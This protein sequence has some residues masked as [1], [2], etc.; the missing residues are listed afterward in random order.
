MERR[1]RISFTVI[2]DLSYDQRMQRICQ[3]LSEAGYEVS[4]IG[5]TLPTSKALPSFPYHCI[6]LKPWFKRG[7]LF[8]LEYNI[9]LFFFLLFYKVDVLGAVDLDTLL[10][11]SLVAKLRAK[12]LVYD[13]HEYFTEVPELQGRKKVQAVWEKVAR[14]GIPKA[15]L[16]YTVS[17]GLA[18][19]FQKNY[20]KSFAVI[21]NL[22]LVKEIKSLEKP[23]PPV[24]LYQGALNKGRCL[25]HLIAAV[26]GLPVQLWIAGEGDLSASLREQAKEGIAKGQI[27]FLGFLQPKEL[28]ELSPQAWLGFNVLE[29]M[30]LSYYYSLAN[31]T[32]D[33]IQAEV[34]VMCSEFPEYL[35]LA[36][37]Y[38]AIIFAEPST[39]SV[40]HQIQT[41]L[42][43]PKLYQN[44]KTACKEASAKWNWEQ[45]SKHLLS[46]YEQII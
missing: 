18:E 6:R 11:N 46:L 13:A 41:L 25:E 23:E 39:E 7:A 31:K 34:P 15:S 38:P 29:N 19:L 45:E 32:F 27:K 14:F 5:R 4:L 33:Y 8:Y 16:C 40:K 28:H 26:D 22:P 2:N 12:K 24:V 9:R 30:G 1:K 37:E 17:P 10:A 43:D 3:S 36:S 44:L 35:S 20:G 42:N 21:R